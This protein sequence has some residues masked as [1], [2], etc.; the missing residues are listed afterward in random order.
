MAEH[1]LPLP[2]EIAHAPP[3]KV[4]FAVEFPQL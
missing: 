2:M 1:P 4:I 3:H